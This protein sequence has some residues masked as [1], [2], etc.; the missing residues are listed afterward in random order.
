MNN[1]IFGGL[2]GWELLIAIFIFAVL[3]YFLLFRNP[4]GGGPSPR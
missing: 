4:G 2:N 3:F 1:E